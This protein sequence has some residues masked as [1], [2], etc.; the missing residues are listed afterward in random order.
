MHRM[1]RNTPIEE[2]VG[3]FKELIYQGKIKSYGLSEAG[4]NTIRRAHAVYP[5]AVIFNLKSK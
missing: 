4:P 5:C 3:A 1:D 2:T